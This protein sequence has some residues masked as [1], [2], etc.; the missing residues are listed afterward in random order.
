MFGSVREASESKY[1]AE[2]DYQWLS[3]GAGSSHSFWWIHGL[4]HFRKWGIA[5]CLS[6]HWPMPSLGRFLLLFVAHRV[7]D[8]QIRRHAW[9]GSM[10]WWLPG[11]PSGYLGDSGNNSDLH[12]QLLLWGGLWADGYGCRLGLLQA[13]DWHPPPYPLNSYV[14]WCGLLYVHTTGSQQTIA[15]KCTNVNGWCCRRASRAASSTTC[16]GGHATTDHFPGPMP[17]GVRC[18]LTDFGHNARWTTSFSNRSWRSFSWP[19]VPSAGIE[20]FQVSAGQRF[21][22]ILS[23]LCTLAAVQRPLWISNTCCFHGPDSA[24]YRLTSMRKI[25][26]RILVRDHELGW[27]HIPLHIMAM[28]Y[29]LRLQFL[30][31]QQLG[32]ILHAKHATC[33]F[34]VS[35]RSPLKWKQISLNLLIGCHQR[36]QLEYPPGN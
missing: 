13:T 21:R 29:A 3:N 8:W 25:S 5:F 34:Q 18:R 26:Q 35:V 20:M 17:W 24:A 10:C 12:H 36:V 19:N 28:F 30:D 9:I 31:I 1:K 14:C 23:F 27:Q 33:Q 32:S 15:S 4:A 11:D 22:L 6:H 16:G 2:N 7:A